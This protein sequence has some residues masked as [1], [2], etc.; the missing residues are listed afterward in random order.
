MNHNHPSSSHARPSA[1][2]RGKEGLVHT[3]CTC[4]IILQNMEN[5]I[6]SGYCRYTC[7]VN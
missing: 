2:G 1:G 4:V 5:P 3:A 6:T 7:T